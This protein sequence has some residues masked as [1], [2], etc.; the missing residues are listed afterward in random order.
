MWHKL[1]IGALMAASLFQAAIAEPEDYVRPT[2]QEGEFVLPAAPS[3]EGLV[4]FYVSATTDNRFFVDVSSLTVGGDGVVRYVL[5]VL[6][7]QGA[8]NV[9]FEGMRCTSRER[10]VYATGRAD[11]SWSTARR[12]DWIKVSEATTNRQHAALFQDY[13]CP[14]GVIVNSVTEVRATLL[15]NGRYD[16][17]LR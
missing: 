8:R 2:W 14:D 10:R 7:K 16:P 9:T 17:M 4:P 6:T 11:G 15:K 12:N 13:F 3:P 5:V 1:S